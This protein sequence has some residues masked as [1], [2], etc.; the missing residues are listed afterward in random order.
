M[1][2]KTLGRPSLRID[3]E[4]AT[5]VAGCFS[6]LLL[7]RILNCGNL[8]CSRAGTG[9]ESLGTM[10]SVVKSKPRKTDHAPQILGVKNEISFSCAT[11]LR[12]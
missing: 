3:A 7:F 11:S 8:L 9:A 1:A 12:I 5:F 2:S 6:A 10:R 4:L